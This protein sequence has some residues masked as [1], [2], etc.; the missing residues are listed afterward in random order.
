MNLQIKPQCSP[1]FY[2]CLQEHL[3]S[4]LDSTGELQCRVR[5]FSQEHP[6][7]ISGW[8]RK[9]QRKN[10]HQGPRDGRVLH[11]SRKIQRKTNVILSWV[12]KLR[13]LYINSLCPLGVCFAKKI[14]TQSLLPNIQAESRQRVR[15]DILWSK[16]SKVKLVPGNQVGHIL[17]QNGRPVCI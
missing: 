15:H 7:G 10:F 1:R 2:P 14:L 13:K 3:N 6:K 4:L 8:R 16:R 5:I 17:P 9:A 11:P 12:Q